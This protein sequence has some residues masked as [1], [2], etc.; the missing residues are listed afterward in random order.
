MFSF[1]FNGVDLANYRVVVNSATRDPSYHQF[2]HIQLEDK[3]YAG[4]VKFLPLLLSLDIS[5]IG[6]KDDVIVIPP[7]AILGVRNLITYIKKVLSPRDIYQLIFDTMPDRYWLARFQS[8]DG[9]FLAP[10]YFRGNVDFLCED[11][12]AF[13]IIETVHTFNIDA[14]PKTVGEGIGSTA[15]VEP[16]YLLTAGENVGATTVTLENLATGQEISWVG[17][18]AITDTLEIDTAHWLVK[19]N[20]VVDMATVGGL[21]PKLIPGIN[22]LVVGG[23]GVLGTMQVTYR[24]AFE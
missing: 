23:F 1:S 17:T 7:I 11:P 12:R 8:L 22:P 16:V 15:F 10:G 2:G 5:V 18:I 6:N 24:N 19:L 20:G 13:H 4:R 21:F 3:A 9:A 14:D